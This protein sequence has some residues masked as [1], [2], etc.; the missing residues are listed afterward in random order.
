MG[1]RRILVDDT[2]T[3]HQLHLMIQILWL[4]DY[5]PARFDLESAR[6]DIEVAPAGISRVELARTLFEELVQ[7]R[8][9]GVR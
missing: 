2:S 7:A 6:L 8:T 1:W 5:H 3:L 4:G 9:A